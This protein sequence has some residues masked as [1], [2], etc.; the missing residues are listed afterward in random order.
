MSPDYVFTCS[1][2]QDW[3]H[4][5]GKG[6]SLTYH[7]SQCIKHK[8]AVLT[9][10]QHCQ[11]VA[12]HETTISVQLDNERMKVITENRKC[13]KGLLECLLYC[14]QQGIGI[15]GHRETDLDDMSINVGNFR[16][17]VIL[18]SRHDELFK[19]KLAT[20][21]RNASWLGHDMQNELLSTMAQFVSAKITA[22]VKESKYYTLI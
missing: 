16:S 11:S 4:A 3:K 15:R 8:H 20:G 12:N 19:K 5:R 13:I 10:N 14:A 1:G 9:W 7:D 6:G 21:P 2:F 22:E 18:R 17:L